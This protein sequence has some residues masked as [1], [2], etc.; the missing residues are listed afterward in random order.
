MWYTGLQQPVSMHSAKA[1]RL[2][3]PSGDRFAASWRPTR[4]ART[5]ST[6][7]QAAWTDVAGVLIFSAVPF[8]AVQALADS[9]AGKQLQQNLEAQKPQL[10]AQQAADAAARARARASRYVRMCV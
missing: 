8:V 3:A 6:R 5:L 4:P 1:A 7:V 2:W 10:L 9:D